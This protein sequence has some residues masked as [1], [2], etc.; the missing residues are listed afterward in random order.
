MA[1][2]RRRFLAAAATVAAHSALTG[3]AE[4]RAA[5]DTINAT[6]GASADSPLL[7]LRQ[8]GF[9]A[10]LAAEPWRMWHDSAAPWKS[11][12]LYLPDD[13]PVI[14]KLPVNAPS[15]GWGILD[16]S[17]G[18]AVM[19]PA[20][21]E[22]Y[23]PNPMGSRSVTGVGWFW[24]RFK[25]P[26]IPSGQRLIVHF[27]GARLRA[28][29]YVNKKLCAYN[30]L[31]ELPFDADITGH[32]NAGGDNLLAVR[33][34]NPGGVMA[35]EDW[36]IIKWGDYEVPQSR[37]IGGLDAGIEL[38]LRN[39]VEVADLWVRNKPQPKEVT[40]CA[41]V[42]NN[43][44]VDWRGKVHL[45]IA[46]NGKTLWQQTIPV[47]IAP[48][49][50]KTVSADAAPPGVALWQP[51]SPTLYVAQAELTD[52]ANSGR[53]RRFGFR[54]FDAVGIGHNAMFMFNG[55]RMVL[56]SAISW[57]WWGGSGLWPDAATAKREV[58]AAQ[59]LGLNC[60]QAHRNLVK[61]SVIDLQDEMGLLRY[62]EPGSGQNVWEKAT[63][64]VGD[65]PTQPPIDTSGRGGRPTTFRQR[66]EWCKIMAMVRRDRSHPSLVVWCMQNEWAGNLKNP[67]IFRL[68][69]AVHRLDP[70]RILVLKSGDNKYWNEAFMLPYGKKI[71]HENGRKYCG[72]RDQHGAAFNG[73]QWRDSYYTNPN[74]YL[75]RSDDK[76]E[77]VMWG[78]IGGSGITDNHA[79]VMSYYKKTGGHSYDMAYHAAMLRK[80]T[81]F[82]K[83][84][85]FEKGF[86]DASK[87]FKAIGQISYFFN[88]RI[89]EQLR[90]CDRTDYI[91]LSGWEST[92]IDNF[93]GIVDNLRQF[94]GDPA[95][96]R[97][98]GRADMLVLK[99]RRLVLE[100][101][102]TTPLDVF[103]V[104]E[105]LPAGVYRLHVTLRQN[106]HTHTLLHKS[107]S[108]PGGNVFASL[109]AEAI[110]LPA[111]TAGYC[112]MAAV[113]H[114]SGGAV[115]A[116][117]TAQVLVVEPV[118]TGN[119]AVWAADSS[120][121]RSYLKSLSRLTLAPMEAALVYLF[122][123]PAGKKEVERS[124]AHVSANGG[125]LAIVPDDIAQAT[126]YAQILQS[127]GLLR[128]HG[129]VHGNHI[130]WM[131]CWYFIRQHPLF[132]GLPADCA[133]DWRY[134]FLPTAAAG[135][136]RVGGRG[137]EVF[138]G[139]GTNP[140]VNVSAAGIR[141]RHGK[142]SVVLLTIPG[143]AE[144]LVSLDG[145]LVRPAARRI[146]GNIIAGLPE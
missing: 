78:E 3:K 46:D 32:V 45:S 142:G 11:D 109:L 72:W 9:I 79:E 58:T 128:L 62:Q 123:G 2:S 41:E 146:V 118:A 96:L 38:L 130:P 93:S 67:H 82:M 20:S 23:A 139:F 69:R 42:V 84:W 145:L 133:L 51:T 68:L 60:L 117:G 13:K 17:H 127:A 47:K 110:A 66:Y 113:L 111:L 91:V 12:K 132:A 144:S 43:T 102:E 124:L 104:A 10:D 18:H 31:T 48:G 19:L 129:V 22:Q 115:V 71:Y 108:L 37:G 97:R 136:L 8:P 98:A 105:T 34:T 14:E 7:P 89:I 26:E 4:N 65:P 94:K 70:S 55:R 52:R 90:M 125:T 103:A 95:L 28:E 77:I 39:E 5:A 92:A 86:G 126:K 112:D 64:Y 143:I 88:A 131:S 54:W 106:G 36:G 138:A 101:G 33:I 87:L 49:K 116:D 56:R 114:N 75:M 73:R 16:Q 44:A 35:W 121:L 1:I 21:F 100:R 57:G 141:V 99:P 107:V 137:L 134:Q 6:N 81:Q 53:Q 122:A 50:R 30:L 40:L 76:K 63:T 135:G 83:Q 140:G 61:E 15:G 74:Q 25:T 119:T 120:P 85:G 29:V 80:Y 24:R 27:R 59:S